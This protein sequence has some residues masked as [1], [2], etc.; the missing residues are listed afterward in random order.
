[1]NAKRVLMAEDQVLM[2]AGFEV[3]AESKLRS[4]EIED[5]GP[6]SKLYLQIEELKAV[7][8]RLGRYIRPETRKSVNK[9][10]YEIS[11]VS[12]PSIPL[13]EIFDIL[14]KHG[15]VT[16]QEDNTPWEGLLLGKE[17]QVIIPVA[18]VGTFRGAVGGT[19]V[20]YTPVKN[21]ALNLY[22]YLKPNNRYEINVYLG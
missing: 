20:F 14:S 13:S 22:W 18:P 3:A 7:E 11:K 10:L 4:I 6:H 2:V 5:E 16:L 21:S 1:M 17:G 8:T 9:K 12:Y 15:L 19:T